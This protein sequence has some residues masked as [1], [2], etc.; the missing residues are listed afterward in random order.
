MPDNIFV[1]FGILFVGTFLL[2][3]FYDERVLQPEKIKKLLFQ[4]PYISE[5]MEYIGVGEGL[6]VNVSESRFVYCN[7]YRTWTYSKDEMRKHRIKKTR[8]N[9]WIGNDYLERRIVVIPVLDDRH[10]E[11]EVLFR[12]K[13]EALQ[14]GN[15]LYLLENTEKKEPNF[16]AE[17]K[18]N[19]ETTVDQLTKYL[20]DEDFIHEDAAT[21]TRTARR[22]EAYELLWRNCQIITGI[23]YTE[24]KQILF[25]KAVFRILGYRKGDDENTGYT[26]ESLESLISTDIKSFKESDKNKKE[27]LLRDKLNA[28]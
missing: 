18:I 21:R 27:A 3:V 9:A 17:I 28:P 5:G 20:I 22:K 26:I 13:R 16:K 8:V 11:I 2:Y 14:C 25:A 15:A 19:D 6:A 12:S 24:N 10:P 23:P 4:S 1:Y 7:G